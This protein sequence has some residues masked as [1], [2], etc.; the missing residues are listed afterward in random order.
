MVFAVWFDP[1]RN[2]PPIK[3]RVRSRKS[4][5]KTPAYIPSDVN[6]GVQGD[7]ESFGD[8]GDHFDHHI[9]INGADTLCLKQSLAR[10]VGSGRGDAS[11]EAASHIAPR[12]RGT[13][14]TPHRCK[15]NFL[16]SI[17]MLAFI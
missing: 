8:G 14:S 16:T 5:P 6:D 17:L 4:D 12:N 7:E 15:L 13:K 2:N 10:S 9:D 1:H 3:Y 11:V